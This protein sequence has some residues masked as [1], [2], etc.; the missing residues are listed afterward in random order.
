TTIMK[1]FDLKQAQFA[2]KTGLSQPKVSGILKGK[3]GKNILNDI[4]YRLHYEFGISKEWWETGRG[5]MFFRDVEKNI[6]TET[7]ANEEA[8]AYGESY[9]RGRYDQLKDEHERLLKE[10]NDIK[11]ASAS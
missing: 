11:S 7:F 4:F 2:E 6:P 9:W 1:H 10:L 5:D 3:D 8:V